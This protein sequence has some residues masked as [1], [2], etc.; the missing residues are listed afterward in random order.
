MIKAKNETYLH[1][2]TSRYQKCY[3]LN[4][5]TL[6]DRIN[7]SENEK[8]VEDDEESIT[9]HYEEEGEEGIPVKPERYTGNFAYEEEK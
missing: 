1:G 7:D 4:Q 5:S 8:I 9:M 2:E 6:I 3:S